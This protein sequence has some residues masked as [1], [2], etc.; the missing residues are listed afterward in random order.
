[1]NGTVSSARVLPA[2][3]AHLRLSRAAR[4]NLV[5]YLFLA[6]YLSLFVV[7]VIAPVVAAIYLS[8]TY[9]NL[10]QP[11][12]WVG[13]SNYRLL[14][15]DDDVFLIAVSNTLTFAVITGPLGYAISFALAW[16]INRVRFKTPYTLAFYTPSITSAIAM[17]VIWRYVFSS[18]RYGLLNT[19]LVSSGVLSEPFP[20]LLDKDTIL[21]VIMFVSLWMSMGTNFLVFLAGLQT[22]PAELYEAARVDGIQSALQEVWYVTLPMM[23]PQLLF[24]AVMAIVGSFSVFQVAIQLAGLP[25]PLYAG[26]TIVAHLYDYAFIRFEMGYAAAIAVI[27]FVFTFLL[28]RTAMRVFSEA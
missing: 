18:D 8:G 23:R 9:Y 7:F 24:G 21:P 25:S 6:P 2:V 16:L 4:Q 3:R 1:M 28:G 13:V 20:W 12:R 5:S 10:L 26:H 22:V 17:S 19:L 15:L 11:P 14:L 27:L